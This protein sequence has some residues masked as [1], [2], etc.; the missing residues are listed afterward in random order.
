MAMA[1]VVGVPFGAWLA[2]RFGWHA[3]FF[4]SAA[5]AALCAAVLIRSIPKQIHFPSGNL[6]TILT[7]MGDR[8]LM[9]AVT[10]TATVMAAVYIVF[11]FF[12]P[13]IEASA[14][15]NPE[16]RAGYLML[17]GIGA[18]GGNYIGGFLSDRFG[19][20]RTLVMVCLAHMVML[21]LFSVTPMNPW[22]LAALVLVWSSFAWCFVPPQ[23][24]RLVTIAPQAAALALAL[25]AAMI[26]AGIAVGSAVGSRLLDWQGLAVLGVSAGVMATL[27][28]AHLVW[29]DRVARR[30]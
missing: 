27:A 16:T 2:Y 28:L 26:Y 12:G 22:L 17:F 8:R 19:P 24:S 4:V 7:A 5:L 13:L 3:P 25:N 11:T 10:Y 1:Q 18:V 21:P 30:T 9:I 23:Q 15:P 6:S 29:S 14:G 20:F